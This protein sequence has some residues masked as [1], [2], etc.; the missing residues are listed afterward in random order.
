MAIDVASWSRAKRLFAQVTS[1][2]QGKAKVT[3]PM[4]AWPSGLGKGLQSPE[5]GFDSRRHLQLQK[6]RSS[7]VFG[8]G[9]GA[10]I[11]PKSGRHDT[12]MTQR[13]P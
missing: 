9:I 7:Q 3:V 2:Y 1:L 5:R 6:C 8:T 12:S 4:V 13:G 10:E 11:R